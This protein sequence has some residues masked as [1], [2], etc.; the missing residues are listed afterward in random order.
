MSTLVLRDRRGS[1]I[2]VVTT[3]SH[4]TDVF[5]KLSQPPNQN[6]TIETAKWWAHQLMHGQLIKSM[7]Y[8]ERGKEMEIRTNAPLY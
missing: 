8:D 7:E 6:Q 2:L 4:A 1:R 3:E 5:L